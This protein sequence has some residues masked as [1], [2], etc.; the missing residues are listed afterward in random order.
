MARRRQRT[1][2]RPGLSGYIPAASPTRPPTSHLYFTNPEGGLITFAFT[3][4]EYAHAA[5]LAFF[6]EDSYA[7]RKDNVG[8]IT[9]E[10]D[11][12]RV[13]EGLDALERI[14][15]CEAAEDLPEQHLRQ[16]AAFRT[17]RRPAL[18]K[19]DGI[20]IEP[21]APKERR[22]RSAES[23]EPRVKKEKPVGFK[24]VPE[25]AKDLQRDPAEIRV[26]LRKHVE[27]P[28]IGWLWDN[29]NYLKTRAV[30]K[31]KLG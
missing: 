16:I 8:R 27:K 4:D 28:G 24:G 1:E 29:D 18:L 30:V 26:I 31:S 3:Q 2:E 21:A 22:K 19:P 11:G 9:L 14:T 12:Y 15:S 13:R 6:G 7:W 23:P 25:L 10:A 5:I 20:E 17:G